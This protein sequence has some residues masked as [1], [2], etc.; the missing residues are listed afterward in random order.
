MN[1][2]GGLAEWSMA[3]DLKSVGVKASGGS[4]PPSSAIII[5]SKKNIFSL[6]LD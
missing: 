6:A 4:N 2:I 3:T 1:L 5:S